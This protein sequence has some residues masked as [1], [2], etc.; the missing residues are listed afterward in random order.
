MSNDSDPRPE[1]GAAAQA[2]QSRDLDVVVYGATGFVG[3]LVAGH[4]AQHAPAG[5][6][7]GLAG[8]DRGRLEEIRNGLGPGAAGW[9]ILIADA[10]DDASLDALARSARVV[11]ST[12][13]PYARYG[14]PLVRACAEAGTDYVDL[15]G[16]VL[17]HRES[18][19]RYHETAVRT[20]ARIVHSCGF[21]SVPSD[22]GVY[23]LYRKVAEDGA[24]ELTDT[25]LVVSDLRGGIS[26]GTVDSLRMQ[27]DAMKKDKAARRTGLSPYSLSPDRTA[28]PDLGRQ[29]DS[30]IVRGSD[31]APG[32]GGFLAPFFMGPYNTRVVRRSAA[33]LGHAYGRGFRYR[34]V[35]AVG[36]SP[37]SLVPAAALTAGMGGLVAGLGFG[38]T[39]K[40]LDRVLPAPG[41]GPGE[42]AR[43]NGRFAVDVHATTTAGAHYRSRVAAHGDPGYAATA[44]MLG[45]SALALAL[46]R[47]GAPES[48]GVLTPATGIGEPL[49]ERLRAHGFTLEV[50]RR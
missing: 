9:P 33:L 13:G 11:I 29:S 16:E 10:A 3:R 30:S 5:V 50:E 35:M 45:E 7:M 42:K 25:T 28:E 37:L 32:L 15:T 6:R 27:I 41:D 23:R 39:R 48:A 34:E 26:G 17:F 18:I 43:A 36:S 20:G 19:D 38:P 14:L 40:L 1:T 24:G 21:D 22:L 4:L 44:V 31:V 8:R 47:A 12:V 2:A 49:A 46:D